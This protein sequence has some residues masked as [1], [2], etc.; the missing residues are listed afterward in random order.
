LHQTTR[1][2]Q[3]RPRCARES[4]GQ[5]FS[6]TIQAS[7]Q[8]PGISVLLDQVTIWLQTFHFGVSYAFTQSNLSASPDFD[9][10][11]ASRSIA[12]TPPL[13]V[14]AGFGSTGSIEWL[15]GTRS[16]QFV[17]SIKSWK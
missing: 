16:F 17:S 7:S 4:R 3:C 5:L 6:Y 2:S 14:F 12:I 9:S 10:A 13:L 11:F 1:S 8:A 15:F